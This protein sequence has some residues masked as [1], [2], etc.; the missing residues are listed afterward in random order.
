MR[1][2][3]SA[4]TLSKPFLILPWKFLSP[5]EGEFV[6]LDQPLFLGET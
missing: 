5:I 3:G 2:S 1:L 4:R 6:L